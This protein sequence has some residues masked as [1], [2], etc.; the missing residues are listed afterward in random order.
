MDTWI[1][2]GI[3]PYH[4]IQEINSEG[5]S[6]YFVINQKLGNKQPSV[7]IKFNMDGGNVN[8]LISE[9]IFYHRAANTT[10]QMYFI[11][12]G[13][14]AHTD[15]LTKTTKTLPFLAHAPGDDTINILSFIY[16]YTKYQE[17]TTFTAVTMTSTF[18]PTTNSPGVYALSK[19]QVTDTT[20]YDLQLKFEMVWSDI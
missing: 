4:L 6:E 3:L 14:K 12:A 2:S 20:S 1:I 5:A 16:C 19:V 10:E 8:Q 9:E 18:T 11:L 13:N 15:Y 7:R 17:A